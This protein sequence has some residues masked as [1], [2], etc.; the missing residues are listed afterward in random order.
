M[1][2][3]DFHGLCS[4]DIYPLSAKAG[5]IDRDYLFHLL[6]SPGFTE[7]ANGGSARAGMPK[8]NRDHLFSFRVHLPSVAKQKPLAAMLDALHSETQRLESIYQN[9]LVALDALKKSLLHQAF[10]G[11]L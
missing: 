5:Q 7:Y 4:A 6:L 3:P 8:V 10:S 11:A 1:A 2:R 9:K